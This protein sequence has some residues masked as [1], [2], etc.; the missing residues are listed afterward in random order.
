MKRRYTIKLICIILTIALAQPVYAQITEPTVD[1][2]G[3][4]T[5]LGFTPI[6]KD[7]RDLSGT[8]PEG[9]WYG[10]LDL[11]GLTYDEARKSIVL[12]V[13]SLQ[14]KRVTLCA[15][16]G[17]KASLT[18]GDLGL[19]WNDEDTLYEAL[20][21]G[22]GGNIVNRFKELKD[23]ERDNKMYDLKISFRSGALQEA[24]RKQAEKETQ[25]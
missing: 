14:D 3:S 13:T 21:L 12:Y 23:L 1:K 15:Q 20:T 9:V 17:Q 19:T 5:I 11:S 4:S 18:V 25:E 6:E 24:I 10:P 22:S 8:I 7:D 2:E 16:N